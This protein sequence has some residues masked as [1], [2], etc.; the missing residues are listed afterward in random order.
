MTKPQT[1]NYELRITQA[2]ILSAGLG[3][4]L[5]EITNGDIPKV[6][7]PLAGKPLLEH[8][9]AELKKYGVRELFVNLH[10]LPDVIKNYFGDGSKWGVKIHYALEAPEILGTAGGIK[11]F[12]GMLHDNFFVLYGDTFYKIDYKNL[13]DFYASREDPIGAGSARETDHPLDSDLVV[14]GD[15]GRVLQFLRKPHKELP[16]K[17]LGM[18]APYIFSDK[19]LQYIPQKKYYEIDHELVPDLLSRGFKYYTYTLK[20]GEFRKD[21][22]TPQRYR[23]VEGYLRGLK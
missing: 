2:V 13:V 15:D 18:S 21:I 5:R 17:Y 7:V 12:E 3:T 14:P 9:V 8:H 1:M 23:E 4:R 19:V 6:M 22:G 20:T 10:Y 16:E 11:N